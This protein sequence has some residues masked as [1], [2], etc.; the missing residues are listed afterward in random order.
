MRS[1]CTLPLTSEALAAHGLAS[2]DQAHEQGRC[3]KVLA[4]QNPPRTPVC[5]AAPRAQEIRTR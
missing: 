2:R 3:T 4:S 5:A 1:R